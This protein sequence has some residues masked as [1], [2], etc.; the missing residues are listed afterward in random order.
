[1]SIESRIQEQRTNEAIK[2]NYMGMEGKIYLVAK[3]AGDEIVKQTEAP[4]ILDFDSIYETDPVAIPYLDE[5]SYSTVQGYHYNG[6]SNGLHLEITTSEYENL[7]KVYYKSYL[8]YHEE[9]G[10]LSTFIPHQGW[11]E[12]IEKMYKQVQ[13]R[14]KAKIEKIKKEEEQLLKKLE[15]EEVDRLRSKWGDLI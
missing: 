1:M 4:E 2:K 8:V 6:L 14:I 7:I 5:E 11:E 15:K 12:I 10:N 3:Y 13:D 9:G